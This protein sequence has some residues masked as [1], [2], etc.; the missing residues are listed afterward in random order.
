MQNIFRN[1]DS[2]TNKERKEMRVINGDI[3]NLLLEEGRFII[4]CIWYKYKMAF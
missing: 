1:L 3:C 2:G 4:N